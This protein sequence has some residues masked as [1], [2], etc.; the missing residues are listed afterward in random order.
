M[1]I[2]NV[3]GA[4]NSVSTAKAQETND[5]SS[6]D[7]KIEQLKKQIE[8][9]NKNDKLSQEEKDKRVANIENQVVQLEQQ[10]GQESRNAS[11]V[12][13]KKRFDT[14][15][16]QPQQQSAGVYQVAHDNEGR[17]IIQVDKS[18]ETAQDQLK[19]EPQDDSEKPNNE[20]EKPII[21]KTT[22]NT[23][24]VDREIE[25]LKQTQA[26]LEQK[27]AAAK[28][29]K[30]KESLETQL[31]QVEAELKLKDNHTYRRQHMEITEQKVVSKV[32]E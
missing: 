20:G 24:K 23:D 15:E 4:S 5:T 1:N 13:M 32:G 18:W 16:A 25:K 10:N 8:Q 17:Q 28:E 21:V 9:I 3:M 29:P 19:A 7:R 22:G 14:Y 31:A 12:E 11:S 26:Q 6:L 27:I 2:G 30:D